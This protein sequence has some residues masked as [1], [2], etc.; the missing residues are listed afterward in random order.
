MQNFFAAN[1]VNY[2]KFGSGVDYIF[3][4]IHDFHNVC[5]PFFMSFFP[6]RGQF[7]PYFFLSYKWGL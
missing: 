7:G 3:M 4:T 2:G 6:E 1:R 5:H